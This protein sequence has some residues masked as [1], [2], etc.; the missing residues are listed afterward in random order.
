LVETSILGV[1]ASKKVLQGQ[2]ASFESISKCVK[3]YYDYPD[4][5]WLA[6][7]NKLT[8]LHY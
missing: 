2:V 1:E 7:E 8:I 5:I 4:E 6:T 3:D